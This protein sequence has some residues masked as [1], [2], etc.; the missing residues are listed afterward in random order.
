MPFFGRCG[1]C[2]Q[3]K[4]EYAKLA[5]EIK[6][7]D[8]SIV[9]GK[10][11]GPSLHRQPTPTQSAL[12]ASA[13]RPDGT[14]CVFIPW[15]VRLARITGP[16]LGMQIQQ[17][18]TPTP[19]KDSRFPSAPQVDAAVYFTVKQNNSTKLTSDIINYNNCPSGRRHR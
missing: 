8:D 6:N 4:P 13:E 16:S 10:V 17:L 7:Y 11:G 14:P 15:T 9:I 5:T 19:H 18:K 3:L 2:K 12:H 1:H